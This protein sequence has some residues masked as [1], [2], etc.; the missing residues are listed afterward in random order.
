MA[1]TS[2]LWM[3]WGFFGV[4]YYFRN[5]Q[6]I[7]PSENIHKTTEIDQGQELDEAPDTSNCSPQ[8][9]TGRGK[10]YKNPSTGKLIMVEV[11]F[12]LILQ[13]IKLT[14]MGVTV[15]LTT[16]FLFIFKRNLIN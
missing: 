4:C 7:D 15:I 10:V 12:K 2:I 13:I 6:V 1:G 16:F 9:Y 8:S 5:M 11:Q 3:Q 14:V